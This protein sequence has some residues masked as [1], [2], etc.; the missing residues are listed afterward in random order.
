MLYNVYIEFGPKCWRRLK[1]GRFWTLKGA[2]EA[3]EDNLDLWS[4]CDLTV[5]Y[6]WNGTSCKRGR[7]LG[8][9]KYEID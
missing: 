3:A 6:S 8:R 4:E 7:E 9:V 5:A 2:L 1:I